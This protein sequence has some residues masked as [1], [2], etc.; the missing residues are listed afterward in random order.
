[1]DKLLRATLA[2]GV[3]LRETNREWEKSLGSGDFFPFLFH[4]CYGNL[5]PK[6]LSYSSGQGNLWVNAA[7]WIYPGKRK[8]GGGEGT[9][10]NP[11][12]WVFISMSARGFGPGVSSTHFIDIN[13]DLFFFFKH[14]LCTCLGGGGRVYGSQLPCLHGRSRLLR[15]LDHRSCTSCSALT[16]G[17]LALFCRHPVTRCSGLARYQALSLIY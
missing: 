6:E 10:G 7:P 17:V 13:R 2:T 14:S 12:W 9:K 16:L 11:L 4:P 5:V 8:I 1:M 15:L 3:K